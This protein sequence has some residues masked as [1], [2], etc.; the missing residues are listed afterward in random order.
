MT[1][2]ECY[3]KIGADYEEAIT[4]MMKEERIVK[5]SGMFLRDTSF[6]ELKAAMGTENYDEAFRMAHTLKG[7]CQNMSFTA[8]F[9]PVQ[10]I[11]EALR[12][13]SRDIELAKRLFPEVEAEYERT[14]AG[15]NE[16][17]QSQ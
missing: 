10:E 12:E 11:T 2:K 5:F 3:E 4:R 16:L 1:I 8:L 7:V 14:T 9:G 17:L 15:I 6:T 13:S